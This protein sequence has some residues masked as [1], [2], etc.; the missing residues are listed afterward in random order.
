MGILRKTKSVEI[1][2]KQ[3]DKDSSAISVITLVERLNS[4]MNKT[5]VYRILNKLEDDGVVHS[6]LGKNGH[7]WYAKCNNCSSTKHHDVHPHFQCITCGKV[8][9]LDINVHIPEIPN[10]NVEIAQVLLQGQCDACIK[11]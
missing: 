7:K 3:F 4:D 10:R 6:F 5:T 1:V 8:D 11:N 9:C 2:V